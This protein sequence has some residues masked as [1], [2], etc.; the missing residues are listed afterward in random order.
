MSGV[1][2]AV[3][4][5]LTLATMF[6]L[7]R[8]EKQRK[9]LGVAVLTN[10][11]VV[12]PTAFE[13]TVQ[14][15]GKD[16]EAP[17]LVVLRIANS[18]NVPI[19]AADFERSLSIAFPNCEVLSAEVT[20]VRPGDLTPTFKTEG[21][22]I[23][24]DPSLLNPTDLIDVQC[25]IDGNLVAPQVECR[26]VGVRSVEYVKLAKTSWGDVWRV[27]GFDVIMLT[28]GPTV[29]LGGAVAAFIAGAVVIG[30]IALLAA[31]YWSWS[32]LRTVRRSR[33]WLA[34]PPPKGQ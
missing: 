22:T 3:I 20:G 14:H 21:A 10:R 17:R 7:Y 4:A 11:A 5:A 15:K 29:A 32:G 9:A 1:V 13:I 31:V 30:C 19:K 18:G 25:L 34:L 27:S 12:T 6:V 28:L 26:V 24:L 16:V 33:L 8:W 23:T 2:A